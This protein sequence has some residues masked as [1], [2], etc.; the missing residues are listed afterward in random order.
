MS[1]ESKWLEDVVTH[2]LHSHESMAM[3]G[4]GVAWVPRLSVAGESWR[5]VS[6]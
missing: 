6:G 3:Q 5:G 2:A 1:L 4:M